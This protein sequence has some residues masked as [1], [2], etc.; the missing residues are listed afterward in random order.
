[1]RATIDIFNERV[2]EI[3]LYYFAIDDLYL[4][5]IASN[6]GERYLEDDFLK[7]LKSN[8]LL[9][10]Y[11]LVESTIMGGVL[12]IYN[13]LLR[14]GIT[15]RMVRTEI[16]KIW[17][18]FKF[19]QVYDKNAHYHSYRDKAAEIIT[20]ILSDDVL[21]LDR[22]AADISGNLDAEKIRQICREHGIQ[23][24][25]CPESRGG[26]VLEDVKNKR[27][28]LAHGTISFVECGRDYTI[29]DL[30]KI[31][32]ETVFF[33]NNILTGMRNYYD[34]QLYL[35]VSTEQELI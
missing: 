31:K 10:V 32:N 4:S 27:N 2:T 3:E 15:Y 26:V 25:L 13:T 17:F 24:R 12:E 7:I 23:F 14:H 6:N 29:E 11:N 28:N 22:K 1:M 20:S 34:N 18:S 19:N 33:L 9:M 16:Q 5:K 35:I 8:A 21:A 30:K